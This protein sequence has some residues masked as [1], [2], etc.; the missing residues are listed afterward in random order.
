[1]VEN[2]GCSPC[3]PYRTPLTYVTKGLKIVSCTHQLFDRVLA[4]N[5]PKTAYM[6]GLDY[7]FLKIEGGDKNVYW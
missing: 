4:N 7:N 1:M 3:D 2:F 5:L 6:R